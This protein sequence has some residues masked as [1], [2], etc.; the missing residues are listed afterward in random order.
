[1]TKRKIIRWV[2]CFFLGW[3][4]WKAV[5]LLDLDPNFFGSKCPPVLTCWLITSSDH[6]YHYNHFYHDSFLYLS[7][8]CSCLLRLIM[9]YQDFKRIVLLFV[10]LPVR[11]CIMTLNVAVVIHKSYRYFQLLNSF[12]CSAVFGYT[13]TYLAAT[14]F[15]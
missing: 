14:H 3:W 7:Q 11:N 1:M 8:L 5:F 2:L 12:S 4:W 10:I 13:P 15:I 9:L 6:F